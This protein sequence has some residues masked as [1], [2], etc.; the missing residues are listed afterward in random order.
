VRATV[1]VLALVLT[2]SCVGPSRTDGDFELKAGSTAKAVASALATARLAADA[3]G[4]GKTTGCYASVAIGEAVA[5]AT[6]AEATFAS[7]QPPSARSD[8][9]RKDL[10][11]LLSQAVDGIAA[12]RITVRRGQLDRLPTIAQ[13]LEPVATALEQVQE[14]Y[15]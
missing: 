14:K 15:S 1:V 7:Y 6:A 11:E 4:D 12:L 13:Q 10:E 8:E 3:A 2:T 5:D 9:L